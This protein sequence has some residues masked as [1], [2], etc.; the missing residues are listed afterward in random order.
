MSVQLHGHGRMRQKLTRSP[1]GPSNKQL[2]NSKH[3][4]RT[5]L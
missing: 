4:L 3:Y 1:T 2:L 5:E